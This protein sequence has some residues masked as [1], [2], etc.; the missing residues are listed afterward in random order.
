MI[1]SKEAS[2]IRYPKVLWQMP[3]WVVI[4]YLWNQWL[5]IRNWYVLAACRKYL[6]RKPGASVADIGSGEGQHLLPLA[7]LYPKSRLTGYDNNPESNRLRGMLTQYFGTSNAKNEFLD[8]EQTP[9]NAQHNLVIA[10]GILQYIH[11]DRR[12]IKNLYDSLDEKGQLVMWVPINNRYLLPFFARLHQSKPNYET[13]ARR[14]RVYNMPELKKLL[15]EPGFSN[16]ELRPK[17]GFFGILAYEIISTFNILAFNSPS[18]LT[19]VLISAGI[20]VFLPLTLLLYGLDTLGLRL[21]YQNAVL[22]IAQK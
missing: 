14:K 16:V 3:F 10:T 6:S 2:Q 12:A 4:I 19:T 22:I 1:F 21:G 9:A 7:A 15:K 13:L 18:L 5:F 20:L 8:I 11:D 17:M